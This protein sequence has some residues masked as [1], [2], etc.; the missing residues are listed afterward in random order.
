MYTVN[1]FVSGKWI[2]S[3]PGFATIEAALQMISEMK[4]SLA[5]GSIFNV[6]SKGGQVVEVVKSAK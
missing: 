6:E 2:C 5:N 4:V 1:E 3:Y